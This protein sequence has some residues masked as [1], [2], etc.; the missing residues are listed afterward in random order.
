MSNNYGLYF[1]RAD[2]RDASLP[3]GDFTCRVRQYGDAR[4][5]S[6]LQCAVL[7]L[8]NTCINRQTLCEQGPCKQRKN[9]QNSGEY[10]KITRR[11]VL[12]HEPTTDRPTTRKGPVLY[13]FL[14]CKNGHADLRNFHHKTT[15]ETTPL[16][17]N[18]FPIRKFPPTHKRQ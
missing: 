12:V 18:P 3:I 10:D 15:V 16:T 14:Y 6:C 7:L 5:R 8:S 4:V 2:H 1:L 17:N 11:V 13:T 9:N